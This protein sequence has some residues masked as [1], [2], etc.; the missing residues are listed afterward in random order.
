M[1]FVGVVYN[2][3]QS[4]LTHHKL[5]KVDTVTSDTN[6]RV[7]AVE[8]SSN[9][10]RAE[11]VALTEKEAFARGSVAGAAAVTGAATIAATNAENGKQDKKA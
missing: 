6:K 3:I 8:V 10:M 2:S 9:G 1:I 11:I 4:C 7:E 5:K